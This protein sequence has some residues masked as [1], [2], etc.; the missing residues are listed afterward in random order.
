MYCAQC[1]Y[2]NLLEAEYCLNCDVDLRDET[3]GPA[4]SHSA[5]VIYAGFWARM[6]AAFLDTLVIGAMLILGVIATIG[7]IAYTGRES[8]IQNPAALPLIYVFIVFISIVYFVLMETGAYG[9]TFGQRWMNIVVLNSN[10]QPLT[11]FRSVMLF[12]ARLVS[13]L[14]LNVGFFT[15]LFTQRKQTLHDLLTGTLVVRQNENHKIP[16]AAT[17][18]VLF[19]AVMVPSFAMFATAGLPI[20]QQ[21]IQK[22]Q[23][24]HGFKSGKDATLAVARFYYNN[25]RVPSSLGDVIKFNPSH[26]VAAIEINPQ[27]GEITVTFNDKVRKAISNKHLLFSPTLATDRSINWKCH[28]NDIEGRLLPVVCR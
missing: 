24:E 20:F 14:T 26:H 4:Q 28:S 1:G 23:I 27:N 2:N 7:V 22:V 6:M 8:I 18:L 17:L 16:I 12:V 9:T 11:T 13:I 3:S 5:V 21:H 25:G 15:R 10:Y 19:Y